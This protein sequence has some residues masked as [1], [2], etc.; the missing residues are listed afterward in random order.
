M[1]GGAARLELERRASQAAARLP[2]LLAAA[3]HAAEVV[4]AGRHP[5]R[6]PG[7]SDTFWQFRDYVVGDPLNTIDWRQSARL[8]N[9]LLVRQTEWEQPQTML[10][11]CGGGEDFDFAGEGR[12]PKRFRGQVLSLALAILALRGG[13]RVGLWGSVEPPR[14]GVQ[15]VHGL[16]EQL[17]GKDIPLSLATPREGATVILVSD[18]HAP[19][20]EV[21]V[22]FEKV[23]HARGRAIAVVIEDPAETDF[24]FQG[25]TQF[26]GAK[27]QT[28]KFFGEAGAV[29]S[30]YLSEREAHFEALRAVAQG[31][32]ETIV[33]HRTDQ[34][35][36][37][38]LLS[39]AQRID[40]GLL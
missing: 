9:R 12:E 19:T 13:E 24:P 14:A 39:L 31:A 3:H 20:D 40:G 26:E 5:R 1:S 27:R 4:T 29:R 22:A 30:A 2:D 33:F 10:L 35:V 6:K 32:D 21:A 17:L 18:F 16:A 11:W 25:S 36:T 23:R 38:L 7:R 28:R 15:N 37:P 8:D 34:P